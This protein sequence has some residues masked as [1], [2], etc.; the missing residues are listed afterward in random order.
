[1]ETVRS[2]K[3]IGTDPHSDVAVIEEVNRKPV[4]N[5]GDFQKALRQTPEHGTVLMLVRDGR[6]SHY[7][8][9]KAK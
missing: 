7:V 5:S 4:Y 8:T 9:L 6:F 2:N 1:M 3:T